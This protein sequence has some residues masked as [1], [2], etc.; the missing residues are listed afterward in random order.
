MKLQPGTQPQC[1]VCCPHAEQF[2]ALQPLSEETDVYF[3]RVGHTDV[4]YYPFCWVPSIYSV[5]CLRWNNRF[6]RLA[7]LD[8]VEVW[9]EGWN[10][11]EVSFSWERV[12]HLMHWI[13][14]GYK[15]WQRSEGKKENLHGEKLCKWERKKVL[16]HAIFG[17]TSWFAIMVIQTWRTGSLQ[18]EPLPV[19]RNKAVTTDQTESSVIIREFLTAGYFQLT[20]HFMKEGL[21]IP[22]QKWLQ[23]GLWVSKFCGLEFR[24]RKSD[25]QRFEDGGRC[26]YKWVPSVS[27]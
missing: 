20:L 27:E 5:S 13:I 16:S 18:S 22:Q 1:S 14:S 12:K 6:S 19:Q 2:R 17:T 9:P 8:S 10:C 7:H 3:L 4:F 23:K 15:A 26:F 11:S 21:T 25:F 24:A